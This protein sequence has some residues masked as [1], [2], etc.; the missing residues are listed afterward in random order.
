MDTQMAAFGVVCLF[1]PS[2]AVLVKRLHDRNRKG[3]WAL[4]LI[5]A[6]MLLAG[7][8]EV[9]GN[10]AQWIIGRFI[11]SLI[12]IL[13]LLELGVFT[14]SPGDNRFGSEPR[15]VNYFGKPDYQ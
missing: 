12:V 14:G 11:P 13:M 15:P 2:S 4:L 3:Y 10:T 5:V 7:N 9:M 8:W 1:W 6:W